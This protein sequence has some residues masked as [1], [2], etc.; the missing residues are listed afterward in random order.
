MILSLR[1]CILFLRKKKS[2]VCL[3]KKDIAIVHSLDACIL[4]LT[5]RQSV[6][7]ILLVTTLSVI[8]R[9]H[10]NIFQEDEN[11]NLQNLSRIFFKDSGLLFCYVFFIVAGKAGAAYL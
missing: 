2:A 8:Q 5:S 6:C 7:L 11:W 10:R 4:A 9:E 3:L 1:F